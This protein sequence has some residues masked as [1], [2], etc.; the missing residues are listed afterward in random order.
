MKKHDYFL[1]ACNAQEFRRRAWVI[2]AFSMI[3]E[4]PDDWK[5]DP[6]PYRLVQTR[7]A[8]FFVNPEKT[9]ELIQLED[10][11]PTKPP[12]DHKEKFLLKPGDIPNYGEGE[13]QDLITSYGQYFFNWVIF[14]YPFG[15]KI[16]YQSGRVM[17]DDIEKMILPRLQD[18]PTPNAQM[19]L[20]AN[21]R[22]EQRNGH[23]VLEL[24]DP[25]RQPIY[26]KEYLVM[27]DSAFYL[28]GF[29]QLWVPAATRKTMTA[30]PG[31]A[32]LKAQLLEKYKDKLHDPAVIAKIDAELIKYDTE[33]LKGDLGEGFLIENKGRKVVRRKLFLMTGAEAGL[34]DGID[35]DLIQ[36]SLSEGW[37]IEKFPIM[38]DSLRA[39]SYNRG[40]ETMLGGEAVKW[41]LRAS[42]NMMVTQ[43]DCG[44]NLGV[45][46]V[47]DDTNKKKYL[48]FSVVTGEGHEK[49][50]DESIGKYLGQKVMIRSP[51]FCRLEKTDYCAVCVGDRLAMNPTALSSAVSEYGSKFMLLFM[52]K[53]HGTQLAL[54]HMNYKT[55]IQ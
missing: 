55:A 14:V 5:K 39:G 54:A 32:E 30:P 36:N 13:Q 4:A 50:N 42:S 47:L 2:S 19:V 24:G 48:G 35:V 44:S 7:T 22:I 41:L 11:D 53:M 12:F 33:Y 20:D 28:A 43:A 52:K 40:A 51:M 17:P 45:P 37:D 10:A 34:E 23:D 15:Q 25:K 18:D 8:Y 1:A 6:Y 49:L 27:A 29:T 31:I 26:V 46:V 9:D 16:R 38:N 21:A 3:N